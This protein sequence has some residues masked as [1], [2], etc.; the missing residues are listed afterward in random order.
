MLIVH[1]RRNHLLLG[2]WDTVDKRLH[3]SLAVTL[4]AQ[5]R[6]LLVVSLQPSIECLVDLFAKGYP[7]KLIEH[8]F[9]K[10]DT[11]PIDLGTL[12][13]GPIMVKIF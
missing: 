13:R 8:S 2:Q 3:Q 6:F 4:S 9:V 12:G 1:S 11:D 5:V 10:T 7:I